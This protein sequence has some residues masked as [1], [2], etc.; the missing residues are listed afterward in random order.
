MFTTLNLSELVDLS[1]W[2][3]IQLPEKFL[4]PRNFLFQWQFLQ[5]PGCILTLFLNLFSSNQWSVRTA[6]SQSIKA[7]DQWLLP[8]LYFRR[9]SLNNREMFSR[10]GK[11]TRRSKQCL[12]LG[13]FNFIIRI[14]LINVF[15]D[16]TLS[17]FQ[18]SMKPL[19]Q[20][21]EDTAPRQCQ[22]H[23]LIIMQSTHQ[24]KRLSEQVMSTPSINQNRCLE[25]VIRLVNSQRKEC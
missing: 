22:R 18:R 15:S 10:E 19:M 16:S 14:K 8:I 21:Q 6:W 25:H 4:G 17:G 11:L 12:L 20:L 23:I 13:K 1:L 24:T 9:H 5:F 2:H 3:R 7:S